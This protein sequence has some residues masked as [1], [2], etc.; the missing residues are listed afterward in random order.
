MTNRR[1]QRVKLISWTEPEIARNG[2]GF[3]E[4]SSNQLRSCSVSGPTSRVTR[5]FNGKYFLIFLGY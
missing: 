5:D 1:T 2:V 3:R 4:L